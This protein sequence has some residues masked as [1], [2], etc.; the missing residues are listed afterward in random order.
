MHQIPF[1]RNPGISHDNAA[2]IHCQITVSANYLRQ[3]VAHQHSCH[4]KDRITFLDLKREPVHRQ[5]SQ[6]PGCCTAHKT[7]SDLLR[8]HQRQGNCF[9][10]HHGDE[11]HRQHIR[12]RIIRTGFQFQKRCRMIFQIQ[13]F[14]TQDI[15]H[16]RCVRR[17]DHRANQK[18]LQPRQT[19][20]QMYEHAY[21]AGGQRHAQCG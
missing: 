10:A 2:Q 5:D 17:C 9:S 14:R 13:L 1:F 18:A 6:T 20:H 3:R 21:K 15:K 11:Y 8:Q 12:Y 4:C 19:Q 7:K 16:R